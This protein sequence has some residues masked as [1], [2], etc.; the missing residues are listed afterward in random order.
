MPKKEIGTNN[1]GNGTD[2]VFSGLKMIFCFG[3]V[4]KG[5]DEK[6]N[7]ESCQLTKQKLKNK[8][9]VKRK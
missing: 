6:S 3:K 1:I 2:P 8:S 4:N 9:G 5:S 7:H